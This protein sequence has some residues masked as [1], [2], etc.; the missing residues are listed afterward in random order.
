ML[1]TMFVENSEAIQPAER[2]IGLLQLPEHSENVY[3]QALKGP[4]VLGQVEV[5]RRDG[6]VTSAVFRLQSAGAP[7]TAEKLATLE[8]GYEAPAMIVHERS[9][10]WFRVELPE[11]SGWVDRSNVSDSFAAYPELLAGNLSYLREEWDGRLWSGPAATSPKPLPLEWLRVPSREFPIR[12][13]EA[14]RVGADLWLHVRIDAAEGCSLQEERL[15]AIDGWLVAYQ[16]SG[17][18]SAWFYSRGC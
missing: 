4:V 17:K 7:E 6:Y 10:N 14:R 11:K 8:I 1:G 12:F 16:P 9:G 15:P 5:E 3:A 13:L 18:T 2:V